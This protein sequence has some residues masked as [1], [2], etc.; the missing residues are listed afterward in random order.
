MV[1]AMGTER[2]IHMHHKEEDMNRVGPETLM[3][4][5]TRIPNN[6]HSSKAATAADHN[7]EDMTI[8]MVANSNSKAL[9]LI[10]MAASSSRKPPDL[11][12]MVVN[13]NSKLLERVAMV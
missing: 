6:L 5:Q 11:I 3:D 8:D 9:D 12:D 1:E 13:S 7:K 10:D 4:L 2:R